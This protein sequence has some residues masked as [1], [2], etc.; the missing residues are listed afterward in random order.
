MEDLG[1]AMSSPGQK[2]MLGGGNPAAIPGM[3]KVWRERLKLIVADERVCGDML[4]NYDTPQG[5]PVFLKAI[6]SFF[7]ERY[8]W[9]ITS[10]NIAV[11]NGSQSA[12][13]IIF[14]MLAGKFQ[15]GTRR[16]ILFPLMPEYIG[17]AD[18]GIGEH[19]FA[20]Y[21]P[22]IKVAGQHEFKYHVDFQ[23]LQIEDDISLI[24]ASRPTN[25]TGNVLTNDEVNRLSALARERN[26]L[27]ML[28][29]AYGAPF[30]N[31]IFTDAQPFWDEHIIL[32][33]SLSKLGLPG[34]R[35]GIVIAKPEIISAITAANAVVSLAN[36]NIGQEIT[37]PLIA[38]GHIT[39]LCAEIITPFYAEKKRLARAFAVEYFPDDLP[40]RLHV[41]EGA[42]FFWLWCDGLP[43]GSKEL[44]R[45]LKERNV[46]V[47]PGDYFF[48]G[49][50]E[51]WRHA[52]ECLRINYS[53]PEEMVREGFK[54][55]GEEIKR[56]Y[57]E[58]LD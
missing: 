58:S 45:R 12:C 46:L 8:G 43:C 13:F 11:T 21:R 10:E 2:Y 41:C 30:P 6:A 18:Q 25:P 56:A 36:G 52:Q 48:Y 34:T 32:T 26:V 40:W 3:Q 31:I 22:A 50:A 51:P 23:K 54:I 14:N 19:I 57:H 28:D 15:D 1:R 53:Q 49:L 44:Y 55:I 7:S 37:A 42:L 33:L 4:T 24:A 16:R 20:A 35:T 38:D 39:A 27:L 47:V 5:R 17:Y 9:K 29:N